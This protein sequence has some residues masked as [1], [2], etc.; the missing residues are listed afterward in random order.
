MINMQ[1]AI[2]EEVIRLLQVVPDVGEVEEEDILGI[3]DAD[4]TTL[5]ARM[6]VI[7]EGQTV[8]EERT[9]SGSVRETLTLNIAIVTSTRNPGPW[10]RATRLAVKVA[11][12]GNKGGLTTTGVQTFSFQP[13]TPMPAQDGRRW[14]CRV[15][16]V[17]ITYVQPLR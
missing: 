12:A 13:E 5:P 4:D 17:R 9:G 10:L 3:L 11:L 16:P 7:Q 2:I 14:A 8:E 6:I 15:M 1:S